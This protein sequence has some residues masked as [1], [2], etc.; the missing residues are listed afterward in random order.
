MEKVKSI[1]LVEPWIPESYAEA[2]KDQVL[3]GFLGPGPQTQAF[4][5]GIADYVGASHGLLTVSGTVALSIA[6]I[7][8]GLQPGDEILVPAYGVISTINAFASIGLKPRLVEI[9]KST[10]CLSPMHLLEAISDKTRAVCFVNFSG[11]TGENIVQVKQICDEK[12]IPLIE[13]SACALG[14]QYKGTY[15][16]LL[17]TVGIYSFSVPKVLTTGQGGI[18]ITQ[19]QAVF[20]KSAAYIDQGDLEWRK[21]GLNR[22]IGSNLRFN[23]V[24]ASLGS[25]QLKNLSSCLKRRRETHQ[26]LKKALEGRIFT[27]PGDEAPLHNIVFPENPQLFIQELKNQGISSSR[28]Y[29]SIPCHPAYHHL[30]EKTFSV[31]DFWMNH[32]VFLPFGVALDPDDAKYIAEVVNKAPQKLY[33][34]GEN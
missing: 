15:S 32:A 31:S 18:V 11:Y 21:T 29:S 8:V 23:D 13:D 25:I 34:I 9:E 2:V 1:P 14:H 26:I 5:Q 24:Q 12:G 20:E 17:G 30:A 28:A 7:G 22:S 19:D 10:G 16:G 27:V 4:A 3:S 33:S 6:A